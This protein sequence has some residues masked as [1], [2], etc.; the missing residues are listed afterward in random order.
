MVAVQVRKKC[1]ALHWYYCSQYI[2]SISMMES[3]SREIFCRNKNL[4][5]TP[6]PWQSIACTAD[7]EIPT[8][9]AE[10]LPVLEFSQSVLLTIDAM[11]PSATEQYYLSWV[12]KEKIQSTAAETVITILT[13]ELQK[14]NSLNHTAC[15]KQNS[16]FHMINH[17]Q[18]RETHPINFHFI[19]R[20]INQSNQ[21]GFHRATS[22]HP[23]QFHHQH[24][25]L[26]RFLHHCSRML[27]FVSVSVI[28]KSKHDVRNKIK[29]R[30]FLKIYTVHT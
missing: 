25:K 15:R 27:G 18:I 23:Y 4:Q 22:H 6:L 8:V 7:D 2:V 29:R 5:C 28:I 9:L 12:R 10:L 13:Y 26:N 16:C 3:N 14:D 17:H 1:R 21:F 20:W 11:F 19:I 30:Q 24:N